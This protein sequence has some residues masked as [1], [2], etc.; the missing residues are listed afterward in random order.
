MPELPVLRWG[1][2]P[3]GCPAINVLENDEQVSSGNNAGVSSFK[4]TQSAA[5]A[6]WTVNH[7]LGFNPSVRAYSVGGR[8]MVGEIVHTS[9]YQAIVYFDGPVAGYAV[10]S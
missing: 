6:A 7:N 10:C 2:L 3:G 1:Q 4:H 9:L 8:E 5:S